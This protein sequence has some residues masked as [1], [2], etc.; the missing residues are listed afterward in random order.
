MPVNAGRH[1]NN[2]NHS[3]VTFSSERVV[4]IIKFAVVS[5]FR[6]YYLSFV[7]YLVITAIGRYTSSR[8]FS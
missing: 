2:N 5:A 1:V 3:I 6:T 8:E 7:V 4:K